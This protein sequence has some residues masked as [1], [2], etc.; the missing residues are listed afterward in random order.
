M[1]GDLKVI[2]EISKAT[3][4]N[5][6][7]G[8]GYY[9]DAVHPPEIIGMSVEQISESI[10][11]EIL[12]GREGIKCGL[13]GEIGCSWPLRGKTNCQIYFSVFLFR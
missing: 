9:V 4:V 2:Q 11:D 7:A 8:A 3:G 13:I 6:I 12:V 1:K 5:V 10:K